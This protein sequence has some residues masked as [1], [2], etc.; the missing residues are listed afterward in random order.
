MPPTPLRAK[1][2]IR[3]Q[4]VSTHCPGGREPSQCETALQ[5]ITTAFFIMIWCLHVLMYFLQTA[6]RL[7]KSAECVK[8]C[9]RRVIRLNHLHAPICLLIDS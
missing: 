5:Y 8:V 2:Y 7:H 1:L 4:L 3:P 6:V 9:S